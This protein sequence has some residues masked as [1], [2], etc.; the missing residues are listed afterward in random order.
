M[1]ITSAAAEEV[2]AR[3]L[4][5]HEKVSAAGIVVGVA[6]GLVVIAG[7]HLTQGTS[8]IGVW[9]LTKLAVGA[10]DD[11]TWDV[12][13][14]SR[15]PRMLAGLVA[16][17]A[18]GAA[19][20]LLSSIARNA[21]ASPD[22]IG[23]TAG[24]TF[25][26]TLFAAFNIALPVWLTGLTGFVGGIIA[27]GCVLLLASGN[28]GSTTRLILAGSALALAL[29]A[30][31]SALLIL[32]SQETVGLYAWGAGTLAQID[33]RAVAQMGPLV[34][35]VLVVAMVAARRL[36]LLALGD[37]T[38][39]VLGVRPARTRLLG[40]LLAVL[41]T[42]ASVALC[43]P[44]GFVG[45]CAPAVVG[46]LAVK[47][48][49]LGRHVVRIPVSAMLGAVVI[50]L[51]DIVIRAI[52]GAN[53]GNE[54]PTGIITTIVGAVFLVVLAW[55]GT[56][57]GP[58]RRPAAARWGSLGSR[59]RAQVVFVLSV[60]ALG[61]ALLVG[62]LAGFTWLLTGDIANWVAGNA[63][64][65]VSFALDERLPRVL[66]AA[67]SGAALALSGSVI[68]GTCRNPLAEPSIIG[69]TAGAGVGAVALLLIVPT[70]GVWSISAAAF[71]GAI[72]AFGIVYGLSWRGG[73]DSDRLVLIGI[74]VGYG[75]TALTTMLILRS[76]PF[77]TPLVLTWLSGSTY[78]RTL[79][80]LVPVAIALLVFTPVLLWLRRDLDLMSLDD[81]TPRVVG[82]RLEPIR[83]VALAAAV[84]LA[85]TSV[86]A[87]GVLGFVGLVAPHAARALVGGRSV[88]SMPVAMVLGALLVTVADTI[89]RTVIAPS[90]VPAGL[91]VAI[92]GAPY[93]VYLLY[94]SR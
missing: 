1:V 94:R 38:A 73:V 68:Q 12:L 25:A 52:A 4:R 58:T 27:A 54:V 65:G 14:A 50:L 8:G 45:L 90:Q 71:G 79:D 67:L 63:V 88:R 61:I 6:V 11:R 23:V 92:I 10:G 42:A 22:T 47:V 81:D 19:G 34:V 84:L 40:T 46:L 41:A 72:I 43:G 37:E 33:L 59:R 77:N 93:F 3:P 16:G 82:L 26:V 85:A 5:L 83:L 44:I 21:L 32:F 15:L 48:P 20:A 69:V 35:A 74:G 30:G 2:E 66:A 55:R 24:A 29:Q 89:G 64:P 53:A 18:L 39:S 7:W 57:T 62:M 60:I 70:V 87:I 51:S 76:E 13:V 75:G 17:L 91:L 49:G 28:G 56:G 80:Q 86:A 31:S 36:D 78:G 9:D